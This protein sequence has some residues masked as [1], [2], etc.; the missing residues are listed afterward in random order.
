MT[1]FGVQNMKNNLDWSPVPFQS[2]NDDNK[3]IQQTIFQNWQENRT[4]FQSIE[5]KYN[6]YP[7]VDFKK[8]IAEQLFVHGIKSTAPNIE[9]LEFSYYLALIL[10]EKCDDTCNFFKLLEKLEYETLHLDY[11]FENYIELL[12]E[13]QGTQDIKRNLIN[14]AKSMIEKYI[15]SGILFTNREHIQKSYQSHKEHWQSNQNSVY[16]IWSDRDFDNFYWESRK[17]AFSV[18]YI[19]DK[20]SFIELVQKFTN[21]VDIKIALETVFDR[22]SIQDWQELTKN[23]NAGFNEKGTLQANLLSVMLFKFAYDKLSRLINSYHVN[24]YTKQ[25]EIDSISA[26]IDEIT[27]FIIE[28]LKKNE[29]GLLRWVIYLL[30]ESNNIEIIDSIQVDGEN[31]LS[32][33]NFAKS[34]LILNFIKK[35]D[36]EKY[37]QNPN[38]NVIGWD[39]PENYEDW[40]FHILYGIYIESLED[41]KIPKNAIQISTNFFN[42]W[43]LN[44]KT[45]Y[46]NEGEQFRN[47]MKFFAF[48]GDR[49]DFKFNGYYYLACLLYVSLHHN[50]V[51][52]W[53]KI[54][55]TADLFF[56]IQDFFIYAD[57]ISLNFDNKMESGHG[58]ALFARIG[59]HLVLILSLKKNQNFGFVYKSV[60]N[61]LL[62]GIYTDRVFDL[63]NDGFR[64]LF[65]Y[66]IY[67]HIKL[68]EQLELLHNAEPKTPEFFYSLKNNSIEFIKLL[69]V[70]IANEIK[71][72]D[73]ID[74]LKEVDDLDLSTLMDIAEQLLE[75]NP[76]QYKGIGKQLLERVRGLS[77]AI[78]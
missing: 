68:E 34:K 27:Q 23:S 19:L 24:I 58:L 15:E 63:F 46:Q 41:D 48:M 56:D 32:L 10:I 42:K 64:V 17:T 78:I 38:F 2:M 14:S 8:D 59:V 52:C 30:R 16:S 13:V 71:E 75:F 11:I 72:A 40:Y 20:N 66:K 6:I 4:K 22:I 61:L 25:E 18:L 3:I 7:V 43:Y 51:E 54:L 45:W 73:I 31:M 76:Q 36:W 57:K 50:N 12:G 69:N 9:D 70:L 28:V 55:L 60:F 35:F 33:H 74:I 65:F 37:I 77:K 44:T 49:F 47:G 29:I 1:S 26:K 53:K 21:L 62:R 5:I 67:N 39:N